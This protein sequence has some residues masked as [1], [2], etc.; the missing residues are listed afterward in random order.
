MGHVASR[1][2]EADMEGGS[3][4]RVGGLGKRVLSTAVLLPIFLAIVMGAPAWLFAAV[5]VLVAA[6]GQWE[7]SGMF[8][9]SGIR[10]ARTAGLLGGIVV[11]ASF[12]VP[13]PGVP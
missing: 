5:V 4:S 6:L 12:A 1:A 13:V 11:T 3:V 7:L 10:S 2:F 9:R 8:A